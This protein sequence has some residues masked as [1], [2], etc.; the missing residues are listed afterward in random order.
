MGGAG[1]MNFIMVTSGGTARR[2]EKKN[3]LAC[4]VPFHVTNGNGRRFFLSW[5]FLSTS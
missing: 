5:Y 3:V 4:G 2:K 1:F